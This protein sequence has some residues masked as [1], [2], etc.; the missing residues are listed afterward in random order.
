MKYGSYTLD[1]AEPPVFID[2]Y[3]FAPKLKLQ[4]K[5]TVVKPS[6]LVNPTEVLAD[7]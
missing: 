5:V 2:E 3:K 1:L 4:I 7:R 6:T